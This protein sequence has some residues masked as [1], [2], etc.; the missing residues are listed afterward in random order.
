MSNSSYPIY[1]SF[2]IF[3]GIYCSSPDDISNESSSFLL[4]SPMNFPPSL[5]RI[6]NISSNDHVRNCGSGSKLIF[7]ISFNGSGSETPRTFG[8]RILKR[9]P[10]EHNEIS[11]RKMTP[12]ANTSAF[13][14][15]VAL[16]ISS[17]YCVSRLGFTYWSL[18]AFC[19][20]VKPHFI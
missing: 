15:N 3:D 9:D 16:R 8:H 13:F 4:I 18:I 6:D 19:T 14:V 20:T 10:G 17:S 12:A 7:N 2:T 5:R 11:S 1:L